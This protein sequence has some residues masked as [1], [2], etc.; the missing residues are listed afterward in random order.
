MTYRV[1]IQPPAEQDI[2]RA[3]RWIEQRSRSISKALRWTRGIRAKVET[4]K[5]QP[6]R[7]P[8]APDS[9]AYGEEVRQLL[10]GKRSSVY[11]ILF[12]VRGDTIHILAVRHAAQAYLTDESFGEEE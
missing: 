7:C 2:R 8:I 10:Y 11:R 5:T 6:L 3:A 4:L 1:I 12:T 9:E